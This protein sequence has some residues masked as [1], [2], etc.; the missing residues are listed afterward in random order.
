MSK[1]VM[2]ESADTLKILLDLADNPKDV[3]TTTDY[4]TLAVVI[5]DELHERFEQYQNLSESS[6][7]KEP[8]K[9]GRP[10]KY[11]LPGQE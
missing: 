7:P 1:V 6:S 3:R 5:P 10:R 8:K 9:R 4:S 2:I 11:Q